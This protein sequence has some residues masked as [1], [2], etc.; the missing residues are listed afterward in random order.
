MTSHNKLRVLIVWVNDNINTLKIWYDNHRTILSKI[1][2]KPTEK[3]SKGVCVGSANHDKRD[4]LK[5]FSSEVCPFSNDAL[6]WHAAILSPLIIFKL[7]SPN[8]VITD[9][10]HK[11]FCSTIMG[12]LIKIE[13]VKNISRTSQNSSF[14]VPKQQ[15][16]LHEFGAEKA[17]PF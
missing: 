17:H 16:Q 3:G 12:I 10:W 13:S 5:D 15:R 14:K 11:Y 2:T 6:E 9:F 8:N 7:R 4:K 1:L